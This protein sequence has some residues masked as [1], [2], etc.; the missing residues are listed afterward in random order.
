MQTKDSPCVINLKD[1]HDA[2]AGPRGRPGDG[3]VTDDHI[4]EPVR[5]IV[6]RAG[7]PWPN[8]RPCGDVD[9]PG[10]NPG[11]LM[12]KQDSGCVIDNR[13]THDETNAPRGRPGENGIIS[14]DHINPGVFEVVHKAGELGPNPR[15]CGDADKPK[16]SLMQTGDLNLP[17]QTGG[18]EKVHV[19]QTKHASSHTTFFD[20]KNG[21]W[22]Q[23]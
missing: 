6:H 18:P 13:D 23:G 10:P 2:I 15:P 20:K 11:S 1:T 9:S 14:D 7:E 19:L 16:E 8:D 3:R 4:S 17:D 5:D 21:L 12:Q 22:R